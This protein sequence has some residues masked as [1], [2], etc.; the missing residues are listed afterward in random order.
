MVSR[1]LPRPAFRLSPFHPRSGPCTPE[2]VV[3]P[4]FLSFLSKIRDADDVD[5][6]LLSAPERL[7]DGFQ[8][9]SHS[10]CGEHSGDAADLVV[11]G[12]LP[13]RPE[14]LNGLPYGREG[15][16]DLLLVPDLPRILLK[17][18]GQAIEALHEFHRR[19]VVP[20]HYRANLVV[21]GRGRRVAQVIRL[22]LR[23]RHRGLDLCDYWGRGW[24]GRLL[25]GR[26]RLSGL[27]TWCL[28]RTCWAGLHASLGRVRVGTRCLCRRSL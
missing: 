20:L 7:L 25:S 2:D 10:A 8:S 18:A 4:Y 6:R 22:V 16:L 28:R 13:R 3:V 9:L 23:P 14:G 1:C 17:F 12:T 15:R 11:E 27:T 19:V 21:V 26:R 24:R 5:H